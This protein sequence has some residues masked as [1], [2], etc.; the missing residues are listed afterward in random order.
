MRLYARLVVGFVAGALIVV[1]WLILFVDD[2]HAATEPFLGEQYPDTSFPDVLYDNRHA[3]AIADLTE[4][5]VV[6]GYSDGTYRPDA[7]LLRQQFAKMI[8]GAMGWSVS[9]ADVCAFVD[10]AL[11]GTSTL[12]PDNFIA[13][14]ASR[15]VVEGTGPGRF[16]PVDYLTRAQMVT[17]VVRAVGSLSDGTPPGLEA[18]PKGTW[19]ALDPEH[20][21]NVRW[22]EAEGILSGLPLTDLDPYGRATRGETAQV[23]YNLLHNVRYY[24]ALG[25]GVTDDSAAFQA[26][27]DG[28]GAGNAV[29]VPPATYRIDET[30]HTRDSVTL[31]GPGASLYM[32]AQEDDETLLDVD[33]TAGVGIVGLRLLSDDEVATNVIGIGGVDQ[34]AA[35]LEVRDLRTENLRYGI[36]LGSSGVT[37][38]LAVENWVGRDDVQSLYLGNVRGGTLTNLDIDCRPATN[39]HNV[40]LEEGNTDLVFDTLRLAGGDGYSLHLYKDSTSPS[41]RGRRISFVHVRLDSPRQGIVVW[42]Y[43]EVSFKDVTGNVLEGGAAVMLNT[44]SDLTFDGFDLAGREACFKVYDDAKG[45]IS[46]VEIRNGVYHQPELIAHEERVDG[47]VVQNVTRARASP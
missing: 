21:Q 1:A 45:S 47:L 43:D 39:N 40:Y 28:A 27:L 41:L 29:F 46:D 12:Y 31:S 36:K 10:V 34:G 13:V 17:M 30:L 2:D 8:V 23:L 16:S 5:G 24:G 32:P 14:A 25:D 19:D 22:A 38:N 11:G 6:C 44:L 26:A 7:P 42:G 33:G 18:A 9:E 20:R 4:R 35:D 37:T 15:G 3:L